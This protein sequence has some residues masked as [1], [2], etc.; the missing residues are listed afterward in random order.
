MHGEPVV[1]KEN[2][3]LFRDG[4]MYSATDY[5][6][7]EFPPPHNHQELDA[8]VLEYWTIRKATLTKT[9]MKLHHQIKTAKDA[10]AT[11]NIPLQQVT[12]VQDGDRRR[13]S[14]KPLDLSGIE[15]RIEWI[16]A[17]LRECE[18]RL[19][20]IQEYHKDANASTKMEKS[21]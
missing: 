13:R 7:P 8:L 10:Q 5:E 18:E 21:A 11:R 16:E 4:W 17:D 2:R 19:T 20:E 12:Y 3:L 15:T 6:G 9:V 14:Y 1:Y